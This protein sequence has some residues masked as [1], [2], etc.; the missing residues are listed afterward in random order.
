ME[1]SP[2]PGERSNEAEQEAEGKLPDGS[3]CGAPHQHCG[4][5]QAADPSANEK[6]EGMSGNPENPDN[7]PVKRKNVVA[8]VKAWRENSYKIS[9][10]FIIK[11]KRMDLVAKLNAKAGGLNLKPSHDE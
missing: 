3:A 1:T 5:D 4:C 6:G 2:H 11:F 7:L 9:T 10:A 8:M